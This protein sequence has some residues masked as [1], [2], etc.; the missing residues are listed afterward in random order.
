MKEGDLV[1]THGMM[2]PINKEWNGQL[3]F[4][5]RVLPSWGGIRVKR[6]SDGVT[7]AFRKERVKQ[8][9]EPTN[10]TRS[11]QMLCRIR[12]GRGKGDLAVANPVSKD[13]Y[14]VTNIVTGHKF[15]STARRLEWPEEEQTDG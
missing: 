3:C 5:V 4:V 12:Y 13:I 2:D 6:L 8:Y 10:N 9:E 1:M 14:I 7:K 11:Q 15:S